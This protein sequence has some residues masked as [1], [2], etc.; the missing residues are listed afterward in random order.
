MQVFRLFQS[1]IAMMRRLYVYFLIKFI[2]FIYYLNFKPIF[3]YP[4][5]RI[6]KQRSNNA[7]FS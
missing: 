1:Y 7:D 3:G 2:S 6:T 5:K 4:I